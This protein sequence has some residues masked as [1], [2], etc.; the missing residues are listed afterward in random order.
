MNVEINKKVK[1]C[2]FLMGEEILEICINHFL[3]RSGIAFHNGSKFYVLCDNFDPS[4]KKSTKHPLSDVFCGEYDRCLGCRPDE[5][6]K[7][8]PGYQGIRV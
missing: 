5:K 7:Q 1:S 6:N 3:G 8:C 4:D 2:W